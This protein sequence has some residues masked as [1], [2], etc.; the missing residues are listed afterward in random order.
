MLGKKDERESEASSE[1][2]QPLNNLK[3]YL[4]MRDEPGSVDWLV[5]ESEG[6]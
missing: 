5:V 3:W 6:F 4:F 2:F 1:K